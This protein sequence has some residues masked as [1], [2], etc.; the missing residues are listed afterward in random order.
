MVEEDKIK[1]TKKEETQRNSV[2]LLMFCSL[3]ESHEGFCVKF[4]SMLFTQTSFLVKI[5]LK[6]LPV[7]ANVTKKVMFTCPDV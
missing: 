3:F 7:Y 4:R 5:A 6:A 2:F 1:K